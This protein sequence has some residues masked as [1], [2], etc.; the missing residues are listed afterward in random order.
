MSEANRTE[1]LHHT[2][3]GEQ[4]HTLFSVVADLQQ[5]VLSLENV[6]KQSVSNVVTLYNFIAVIFHSHFLDIADKRLQI[7]G[8]LECSQM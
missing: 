5:R 2:Q 6:S 7:R 1:A 3:A 4:I 8:K